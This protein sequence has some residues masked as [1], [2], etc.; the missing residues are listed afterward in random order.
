MNTYYVTGTMLKITDQNLC[1][2]NEKV[3]KKQK[4]MYIEDFDI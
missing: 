4:I 2:Q 3:K 1:L